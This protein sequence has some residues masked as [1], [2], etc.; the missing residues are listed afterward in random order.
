[1]LVEIDISDHV[2]TVT[3]ND[4]DRRNALGFAMFDALSEA[5]DLAEADPGAHVV[6]LG[7]SGKVFCAGFDI[8]AAAGDPAV[9]GD[10][11]ERLSALLRRLRRMPGICVAAVQ[12][13][14]IAGGCA[15]VSACD[16]AV[17]SATAKLGYPVHGLGIS[18]AVSAPTLIGAVGPGPARALMLGGELIDGRAAHAMGLAAR[19]CA[20]DAAVAAEARAL[21][22]VIAAN[23]PHAL[24]VTKAWLNELDGSLDD[25]RFDG[26]AR[27]TAALAARR[28]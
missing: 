6:L 23:A 15:L 9:M 12:G 10:F 17:I 24:G 22:A 2:A 14:A 18:P 21:C 11:I 28:S 5:L 3:L 1:M 16:M 19:L 25:K 27:D 20:D 4:P 26:P 7:G 13:A 8:K